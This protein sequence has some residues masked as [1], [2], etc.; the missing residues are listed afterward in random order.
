MSYDVRKTLNLSVVYLCI[1]PCGSSALLH[2]FQPLHGQ[3]ISVSVYCTL[4]QLNPKYH[5]YQ[6]VRKRTWIFTIVSSTSVIRLLGLNQGLLDWL[7]RILYCK[8][9]MTYDR[10]Y[11][12][13]H[14]VPG[15]LAVV[16]FGSFHLPPPPL[17]SVSKLSLGEGGRSQIIGRWE[18]LVVYNP[19]TKPVKTAMKMKRKTAVN[20]ENYLNLIHASVRWRHMGM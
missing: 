8:F 12:S 17:F 16:W 2:F 15:F 6:T 19:L 3:R 11:F 14:R 9:A 20:L 5:W 10:Q 1:T 4:Q 18:S 13:Y 7:P